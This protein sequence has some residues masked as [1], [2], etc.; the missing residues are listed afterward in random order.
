MKNQEELLKY[1]DQLMEI[2]GAGGV[3]IQPMIQGTELFIGAKKESNFPHV[4]LCGLGGIFVEV[5]KDVKAG[6]VPISKE[7]ALDMI[8]DLK[9]F[10]ILKGVRGKIGININAYAENI[11][12]V[13]GLLEN[14]P[15]D[16]GA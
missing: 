5:L 10:P 14:S 12:K 7:R 1:F 16:H 11:Q 9:A 6:M 3:Q 15:G 13:S 2:E 4:V 8:G